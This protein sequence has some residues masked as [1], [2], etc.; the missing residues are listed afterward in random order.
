MIYQLKNDGFLKGIILS[1]PKT[2]KSLKLNLNS[3]FL[4]KHS[5]YANEKFIIILTNEEQQ[6]LT[7][8][9]DKDLEIKTFG[10]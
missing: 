4:F 9:I 8:L 2:G 1:S 10:M 6:L 5:K 3:Q 7:L